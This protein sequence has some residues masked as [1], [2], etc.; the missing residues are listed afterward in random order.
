MA[1]VLLVELVDQCN[2]NTMK[3]G[4]STTNIIRPWQSHIRLCLTP[5]CPG[6]VFHCAAECSC[7]SAF[8][9][10]PPS[11]LLSPSREMAGADPPK[12]V[13]SS[14]VHQQ[15]AGVSWCEPVCREGQCVSAGL[16][17]IMGEGAV[18]V[19]RVL[20]PREGG[21]EKHGKKKLHFAFQLPSWSGI[22]RERS[23]PHQE[24]VSHVGEDRYTHPCLPTTDWALVQKTWKYFDT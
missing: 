13:P 17:R 5:F 16:W 7:T 23:C 2:N 4:V 22:A 14:S 15:S 9:P 24:Q 19:C 20:G 6:P 11:Y 12:P 10:F 1:D 21:E 18:C 3:K 8:S